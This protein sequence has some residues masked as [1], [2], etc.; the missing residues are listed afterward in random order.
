MIMPRDRGLAPLADF[1]VTLTEPFKKGTNKQARATTLRD[2]VLN[3]LGSFLEVDRSRSEI[4]GAI[5]HVDLGLLRTKSNKCR[6]VPP[7]FKR[8]VACYARSL[9]GQGVKRPGQVIATMRT[10]LRWESQ[11]REPHQKNI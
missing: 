8:A 6:R 3:T 2:D 1:L 9:R 4:W 7:A 11:R 10:T 5:D